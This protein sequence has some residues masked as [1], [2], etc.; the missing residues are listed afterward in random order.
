MKVLLVED[1]PDVAD[2]VALA[3]ERA[4]F[5]VSTETDG[6]AGL[7]HALQHQPEVVILDWVMP[8]MSGVEV[9]RA[10]R[11]DS[12]TER[13]AVLLLTS[14]TQEVDIDQG[15]EAG[16]NDYMVKPVRGRELV[17]RVDALLP[18]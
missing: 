13:T 10:L 2:L 6:T 1:D 18:R 12:R 16:A 14:R 9:C 17:S 7:A 3:L 5:E 8:N 11:A 4:G 15:F